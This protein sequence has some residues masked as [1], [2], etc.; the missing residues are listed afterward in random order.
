MNGSS[1][2]RLDPPSDPM[3]NDLPRMGLIREKKKDMMIGDD[4]VL[5]IDASVGFIPLDKFPGQ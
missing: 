5:L 3:Q 4:T 2:P 1:V